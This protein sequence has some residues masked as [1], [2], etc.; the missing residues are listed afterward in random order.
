MRKIIYTL[1]INNYLPELCKLT[2]PTIQQYAKRIGAEFQLITVRQYPDWPITY[3]KIQL[4]EL[5]KDNDWNILIDA[6]TIISP[7]LHDVTQ[8]F[9]SDY[10]GVQMTYDANKHL[11]MD[12][13]F[14]KDGRNIGLAA[15]FV[16]T[17][18]ACHNL[19][20]PFNE[21]HLTILRRLHSSKARKHIVD[22]YC[23]SQNFAKY[24]MKL[25][26]IA[27]DKL[28]LFL[29][30]N[31][32]TDNDQTLKQALEYMQQPPPLPSSDLANTP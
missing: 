30:L 19:W 26:G 23:L 1:N 16:V 21:N 28:K 31:A 9:P 10:V 24:G 4:Y 8:I 6:D 32:T 25:S 5:G 2:L 7:H 13:Y 12:Y 20:T 15:N 29:H 14:I 17:S 11:P 22:E 18:A 27:D 3:E